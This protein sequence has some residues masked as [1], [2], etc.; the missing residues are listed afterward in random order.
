MDIN[1]ITAKMI[2]HSEWIS[3]YGS[4]LLSL[5]NSIDEIKKRNEEHGAIVKSIHELALSVRELTGK[6]ADVDG[7]LAAVEHDRRQKNHSI[8]QMA[9]SAIIGGMAT[10]VFSLITGA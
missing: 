10:Y 8:W 3:R 1:Q 2:E 4:E 9:L 7:R 6:V 5:S